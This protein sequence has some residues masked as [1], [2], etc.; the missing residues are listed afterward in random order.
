MGASKAT[1]TVFVSNI[2]IQ[3]LAKN[4]RSFFKKFGNILDITLPRKLDKFGN[5]YGFVKLRSIFE[6]SNLI[7]NSKGASFEGC[8]LKLDYARD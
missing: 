6:A 7:Q 8:K 2:P 4:L 3:A 1:K 5:R